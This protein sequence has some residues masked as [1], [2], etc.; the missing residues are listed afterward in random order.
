MIPPPTRNVSTWTTRQKAGRVLWALA[1]TFLFRPSPHNLYGFRAWL[2]R[3]FGA[4]IGRNVR[5]RASVQIVIPWNIRID[6]DTAVG[7]HAILYALGPI[8]IGRGSFI[9][10]YA[11][12]CAGTHDHTS[13]DYPLVRAPITIG[14]DCWIAAQAFVGP[15][16]TIG[17]RSVIG[18]CA[19]VTKD[20]P[21]DQI[22][23]GNPARFL[24]ART[25]MPLT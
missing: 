11:H 5:I 21:A 25:L 9:S 13:L 16:V 19:V 14:E 4:R 18:A 3:C 23:A 15:A 24:K 22:W 10:Q 7:D 6:D 20:V 12:L 2:L 1:G 17:D 8:H